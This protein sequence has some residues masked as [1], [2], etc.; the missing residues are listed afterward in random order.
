MAEEYR[1][2]CTCCGEWHEGVPD[3]AFA[4]PYYY[5]VLSEEQKTTIAEKSEDLC[6][7]SDEDFFIRG[8]LNLPVLGHE[9][10]FG[11]GV[12]VSLS[13]TN[14]ERYVELFESPDPTSE[15]PYF[16]W[17]SNRLPGYPDTLSLKTNVYLQPYPHRPRIVLEPSE[18]LLSIHQHQGINFQSLQRFLEANLH[19]D[20]PGA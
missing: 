15:N 19:Q 14:F 20:Q 6:S 16:G 5:E 2:K 13:R 10:D 7:I 9:T 8:V 11:L 3:L 17:F 12:W 1:F 4:A 18:H